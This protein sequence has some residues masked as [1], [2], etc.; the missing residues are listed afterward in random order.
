MAH[1]LHSLP[2]PSLQTS[3]PPKK[4][5][6]TN[7]HTQGGQAEVASALRHSE[8]CGV[9]LM[10]N[11]K[12]ISLKR[13]CLSY[14]RQHHLNINR[15]SVHLRESWQC[16]DRAVALWPRILHCISGGIRFSLPPFQFSYCAV[17]GCMRFNKVAQC[18]SSRVSLQSF[19]ILSKSQRK[20]LRIPAEED[21]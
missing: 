13:I 1:L 21:R 4:K 8:R 2:S 17:R 12:S 15:A 14:L 18:L 3:P 11:L 16:G 7:S 20:V 5:I 19:H 9:G 10:C 6:H